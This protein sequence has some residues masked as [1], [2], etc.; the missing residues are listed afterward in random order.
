[1]DS[2]IARVVGLLHSGEN[3]LFVGPGRT[4]I[5]QLMRAVHQE[6]VAGKH[7]NAFIIAESISAQEALK[8]MSEQSDHV[9]LASLTNAH[10]LGV[11][12]AFAKEVQAQLGEQSRLVE[13]VLATLMKSV[14]CVGTQKVS[15]REKLREA[16][17][18]GSRTSDHGQLLRGWTR[19]GKSCDPGWELDR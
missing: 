10:A 18:T 13:T 2:E 9:L 5:A 12:L 4:Y 14:H 19:E 11:T 6:L 15:F 16:K 3:V 7:D 1:M 17:Y 8:I